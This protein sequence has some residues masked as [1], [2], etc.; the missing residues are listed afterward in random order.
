MLLLNY[1]T[2]PNYN[3]ILIIGGGPSATHPTNVKKMEKLIKQQNPLIISPN[4]LFPHSKIH[5][6]YLLFIDQ[7]ALNSFMPYIKK[8]KI[9]IGPKS[10]T[11]NR[12]KY[13][14]L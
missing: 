5:I 6:D 12:F 8:E 14:Y 13:N 2:V 10:K 3:D 11:N 1:K 9:I 7:K 4:R